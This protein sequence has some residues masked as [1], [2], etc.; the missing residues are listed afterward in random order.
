MVIQNQHPVQGM[1][2]TAGNFSMGNVSYEN[3]AA[4]Q[5]SSAPTQ[6]AGFATTNDGRY[7]NTRLLNTEQQQ[8]KSNLI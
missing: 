1:E 3:Q 5:H 7:T 6:T 2:A 8:N 4:F